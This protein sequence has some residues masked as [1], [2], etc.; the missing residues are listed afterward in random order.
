MRGG[1]LGRSR[2]TL[3]QESQLLSPSNQFLR[4]APSA[5][6][7]QQ[8]ARSGCCSWIARRTL[9]G[10]PLGE[11]VGL[12]S[13]GPSKHYMDGGTANNQP[14]LKVGAEQI[15]CSN[16]ARHTQQDPGSS[17]LIAARR[18]SR[19]RRNQRSRP[20]GARSTGYSASRVHIAMSPADYWCCRDRLVVLV[21]LWPMLALLEFLRWLYVY[22][23]CCLPFAMAPGAHSALCSWH[24]QLASSSTPDATILPH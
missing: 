17:S 3:W 23:W 12:E 21:V 13:A 7:F 16:N 9:Q 18:F 11:A 10:A 8:S 5:R 14:G 4:R 2:R 19:S 1:R 22:A 20:S 24:R 15:L 6:S